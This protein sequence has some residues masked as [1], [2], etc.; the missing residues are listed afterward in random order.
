MM[1]GMEVGRLAARCTFQLAF[2][3]GLNLEYSLDLTIGTFD[4]MKSR[5]EEINESE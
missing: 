2:T 5:F 4:Q 3:N 1:A